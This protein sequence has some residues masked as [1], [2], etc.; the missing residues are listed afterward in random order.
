MMQKKILC[1][2]HI[3]YFDFFPFSWVRGSVKIGKRNLFIYLF[4]NNFFSIQ[5][6]WGRK[7]KERM[8]EGNGDINNSIEKCNN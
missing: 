3:Y 5:Q 1:Y 2:S 7:G 4:N 6:N 8:K